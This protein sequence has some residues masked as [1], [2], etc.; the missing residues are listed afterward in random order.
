MC[1]NWL[2]EKDKKS[3]Q[4]LLYDYPGLLELR[5]KFLEMHDF[6]KLKYLRVLTLINLLRF[7]KKQ[8]GF[9]WER[10][11]NGLLKLV[12]IIKDIAMGTMRVLDF[13]KWSIHLTYW[14]EVLK[15]HLCKNQINSAFIGYHPSY[16]NA[17]YCERMYIWRIIRSQI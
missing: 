12:F 14:I 4:H 3:M 10:Y 8:N 9:G 5:L 13:S 11:A 6:W 7:L 17:K 16:L 15:S 2:D 1:R